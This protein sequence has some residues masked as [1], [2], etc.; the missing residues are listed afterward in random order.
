[1]V[2]NDDKGIGLMLTMVLESNGYEV[3]VSKNPDEAEEKIITHTIDVVFL[4][5]LI[6]RCYWH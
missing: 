2:V 1:M 6:R 3:L 5:T 4:D